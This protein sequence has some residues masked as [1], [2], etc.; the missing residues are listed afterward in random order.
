MDKPEF[1]TLGAEKVATYQQYNKQAN[2]VDV[3]HSLEHKVR[4]YNVAGQSAVEITRPHLDN[5][6]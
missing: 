2:P 6:R 3:N 5:G 4:S 1:R